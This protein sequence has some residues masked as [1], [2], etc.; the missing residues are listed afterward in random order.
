[1]IN[2]NPHSF[3]YDTMIAVA[4][5]ATAITGIWLCYKLYKVLQLNA[6]LKRENRK[7]EGNPNEDK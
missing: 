1:M 7:L 6:E 4:T 5:V 3:I 2:Q